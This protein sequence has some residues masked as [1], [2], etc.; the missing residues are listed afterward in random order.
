MKPVKTTVG[1]IVEKD[2]KVLLTLRNVEPFNNSW[3]IPG[4]H[5]DFSEDPLTA[6]K[7]EIKEETNLKIHPK[8][9]KF[10]NEYH[11]NLDWHA[12]VLMFYSNVK[13]EIKINEEVKEF[14]W[15]NKEEIS[16]LEFA[17]D[18]KDILQDFLKFKETKNTEINN[19]KINSIIDLTKRLGND[20]NKILQ[21][22]QQHTQEIKQLYEKKDKHFAVE[23][24]DL[25][26]LC[27]EL[28]MLEGYSIE[29][30][31]EKGYKRFDKK[32]KELLEN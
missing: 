17:F 28:L 26:I 5:I 31:L 15:F 11:P 21:M 6:V 25:I 14:R 12:I 19:K 23:T 24:G 29:D 20:T 1:C 4:G 2:K 32:L 18:H 30:I 13:G 8:F 7:R 10:F 16:D 3:C 9:F 22:M 27:L